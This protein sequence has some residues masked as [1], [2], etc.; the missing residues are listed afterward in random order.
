MKKILILGAAGM[1][2]HMITRYLSTY[3]SKYTIF[4][5]ARNNKYIK[6]NYYLDV[7]KDKDRKQLEKIIQKEKF[8]FV[9][10]CIG[11]LVKTANQYPD[12]A[13]LINSFFPHF[14]ANITK[15][16][17]TKIIH[18]STDCVFSGKK[19]NYTENDLPDETNFYGR[20]KALGEIN[21]NKDLTIRLSII[22]VELKSDGTGLLHWFL[23]QKEKIK[24][25]TRVYWNGITTL[26]LA[27]AIHMIIQKNPELSGLYQLA[28]NF[29]V[30]KYE[31]LKIANKVFKKGLKIGKNPLLC[32]NKTLVNNR[33]K[34][35]RY[36]I[37]SYKKQL[38]DLYEFINSKNY[39]K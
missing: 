27:K 3:K 10:N 39:E 6:T 35:F 36:K 34:D 16:I 21:N 20:S 5:H 13:I 1:A 17:N 8:D 18:L 37:P 7:A 12:K 11:I 28:P 24:G 14:L 30:T 38:K 29:N 15:N 19:G 4:T 2:G 32:Q 23:N 25:Y 22:G 33:K 31:L 26:E 9:I